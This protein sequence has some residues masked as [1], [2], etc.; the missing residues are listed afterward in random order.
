MDVGTDKINSDVW[1]EATMHIFTG[2][3]AVLH[4]GLGGGEGGFCA[5]G[6]ADFVEQMFSVSWAR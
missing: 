4:F 2:G 3:G 1:I 6:S 5:R